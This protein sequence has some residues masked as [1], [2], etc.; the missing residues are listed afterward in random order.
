MQPIQL[1]KIDGP[2]SEG[3]T[4]QPADEMTSFFEEAINVIEET[5][6]TLSGSDNNQIGKGIATYAGN[7]DFYIDSGTANTYVLA[8]VGTKQAPPAYKEGQRVRFRA[9]NTNTGASTVNVNGV[10]TLNILLPDGEPLP[11]DTIS[12]DQYTEIIYSETAPHFTIITHPTNHIAGVLIADL[13][14]LQTLTATGQYPIN[15]TLVTDTFG[16]W[17]TGAVQP[18]VSGWYQINLNN[19]ISVTGTTTLEIEA[20]IALYKNGVFLRNLSKIPAIQTSSGI[21]DLTSTVISTGK[22]Y[23]DATAPDT[24]SV[25]VNMT[26]IGL[27]SIGI[28]KTDPVTSG[29][30]SFM[31]VNYLGS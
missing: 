6:Q 15:Y 11:A 8:P 28:V 30:I 9:A 22:F 17:N 29:V 5:D 18:K 3:G 23:A 27:E 1:P 19:V 21:V 25:R 26:N 7:G 4:P 20:S 12:A 31:E 2:A 10:G 16:I 14:A 13:T 24:F